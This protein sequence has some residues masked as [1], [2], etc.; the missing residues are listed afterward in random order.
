[1]NAVWDQWLPAGVAPARATVEAKLC[2]PEMLVELSAVAALQSD[3]AL[4]RQ[5]VHFGLTC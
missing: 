2:E 3:S 5:S 4:C 1:M